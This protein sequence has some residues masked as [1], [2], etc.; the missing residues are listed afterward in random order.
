VDLAA[1]PKAFNASVVADPLFFN[2]NYRL[3]A[4]PTYEGRCPVCEDLGLLA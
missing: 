1:S 2:Y 4:V 3:V